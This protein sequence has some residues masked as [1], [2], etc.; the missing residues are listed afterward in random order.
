MNVTKE[1]RKFTEVGELVPIYRSIFRSQFVPRANVHLNWQPVPLVFLHFDVSLN[2]HRPGNTV[3]RELH[4][5]SSRYLIPFYSKYM[6]T[7]LLHPKLQFFR[8]FPFFFFFFFSVVCA[9]TLIDTYVLVEILKISAF[10]EYS[11]QFT[12]TIMLFFSISPLSLEKI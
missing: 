7:S 8:I 5:L 2:E 9:Y 12:A 6:Y 10:A 4:N 1:D 11:L 3:K